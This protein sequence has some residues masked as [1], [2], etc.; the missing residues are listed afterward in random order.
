MAGWVGDEPPSE[1]AWADA[2]RA[3][4]ER[5][6]PFRA[7]D[8]AREGL[9]HYPGSVGL[10]QVIARALVRTGSIEKALEFLEPLLAEQQ[11]PDDDETH[12]LLGR[13]YKELYRRDPSDRR[14]LERSRDIYAEGYRATAGVYTG[15]NAATMSWVCGDVDLARDIALALRAELGESEST[16]YWHHA[17]CGEIALLL[18]EREAAVDAYARGVE[19]AGGRWALTASS[20]EQLSLLAGAGFDVPLEL[21]EMLR[22]PVVALFTGHMMDR[23]GRSPRFPASA[24]GPV[25]ER[26]AAVLDELD[27]RI[28]FSSAA[29][30]SDLLFVEA[31]K[32]RGAEVHLVLP[33][34]V[35][36][37]VET[38]VGFA[39]E[40]W[41]RRF[42]HA[43]DTADSVKYVTREPYMNDPDL[44]TF[45]NRVLRGL[46][47]L[48]AAPLGTSP[49]LVAVYNGIPSGARGGTSEIVESWADPDRL[50]VIDIADLGDTDTPSSST[51]N[52]D[53]GDVHR[54][55]RMLVFADV[56]GYSQLDEQD[57]PLFMRELLARTAHELRLLQIPR[58]LV[59]TWGDAIF[60][61]LDDPID[62]AKYALA[63]QEAISDRD[64]RAHGMSA[65]LSVRVAVHAGPVFV[66]DDPITERTTCYGSHVN[67]AARLEPITIPG[68]V[69]CTEQFGAIL[70]ADQA[71][72]GIDSFA[73]DYVSVRALAKG[74][75]SEPVYRLRRQLMNKK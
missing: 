23:P 36:D 9:A 1:A 21:F 54:E 29:C 13:V 68:S 6:Q 4:I 69:Y 12:G 15:I 20:R 57:T 56:V 33:F 5:G 26:I 52:R 42:Q 73:L 47:E 51:Y 11:R 61:V 25:R 75:G 7:H 59:N 65:D 14:S 72:R 62:A 49:H 40:D 46:V 43:L 66:A 74:F 16:D 55:V 22:P 34:R 19:L 63:L 17:T 45:A 3:L 32:A 71:D 58:P 37:F 53:I 41:V 48:R 44:F 27:A 38:S 60:A 35:T 2:A 18:G 28:G 50:R 70:A 8:T 24:E 10:R 64:W 31:M 67:R 39:G 30:G